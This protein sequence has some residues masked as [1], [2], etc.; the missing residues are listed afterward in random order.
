MSLLLSGGFTLVQ[1]K[2]SWETY[3]EQLTDIND[4]ESGPWEA[5]YKVLGELTEHPL[6]SNET[7]RESL[8]QP[9]FL[10]P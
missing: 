7:R 3:Y 8:K 10:T 4:I 5:I 9:P 2:L 6:D 1:D